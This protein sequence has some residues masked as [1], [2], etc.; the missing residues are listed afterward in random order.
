MGPITRPGQPPARPEPPQRLEGSYIGAE[1]LIEGVIEGARHLVIDGNV[2]GTIGAGRVT[3]GGDARVD[4]E[5]EAQDLTINGTLK[6]KITTGN[7]VLRSTADV[8]ADI[9]Y[10]TLGIDNGA[11]I[12]ATLHC[13]EAASARHDDRAA[14]SAD[15]EDGPVLVVN[16]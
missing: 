11:R 12:N 2:K 8:D 5:I 10:A 16:G 13:A 1:L 3:I 4:G 14:A 9:V 7:L 15:A 6:G